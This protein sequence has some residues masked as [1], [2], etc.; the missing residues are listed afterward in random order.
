M[1]ERPALLD[2]CERMETNRSMSEEIVEEKL[3]LR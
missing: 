1:M 2:L 3:K